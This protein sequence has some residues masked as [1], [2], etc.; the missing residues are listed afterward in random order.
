MAETIVTP[1]AE[2]IA[3][4]EGTVAAEIEKEPKGTGT[5]EPAK[6][7]ETVPL[8]VYLSLKDDVKELRREIKESSGSKKSEVALDGVE[9]LSK[10]Y[11]DVSKDF[12]ADILS[13]STSI[14][15]KNAEQKYTPIFKQQEAERQKEV[16]DKAF[17]KV[18]DKALADNA[19]L[20][21]NIDKEAVKALALTTTYRNTPVAEI[22][23][24]LYGG[25]IE[26][27][28]ASENE[29]RSGDD[30][31]DDIVDFSKI[32]KEQKEKVLENPEARKKYFAYLDTL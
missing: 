2:E 8:A 24:K 23:A 16:F 9:D 7:P 6:E 20:P 27:K 19:D 21:K 15:E 26:G 18:Y 32:T 22:L 12:I 13:A 1:E 29:I 4:K 30:T 10:K 17:D 11:P 3:P 14:A 28:S 25:T 5:I 31:I